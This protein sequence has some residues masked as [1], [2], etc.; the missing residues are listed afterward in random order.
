MRIGIMLGAQPDPEASI[1]KYVRIARDVES[2]GFSSLW[3]AHISEHDAVM[4][5]AL[6]GRETEKLEV[7]TAVVAVQPRHPV[8]LAQQA[9]TAA[10]YTGGR[11]TLG[12]GLAHKVVIEDSLGL[13]FSRP[14]R[15]MRE[16]L[17]VLTPLLN[18]ETARF[19]GDL[20]RVQSRVSV[21]DAPRPVPLLLAALGPM[22]LQIAGEMSDGT[23]LWMTG[24]KTIESHIRPNLARAAS[25]AGRPEPRIV[26]AF[27]IVLTEDADGARAEIARR[28]AVYGQLPSYRAMLDKEGATGPADVAIAGDER[29][30]RDAIRRVE[31]AGTTDFGAVIIET[32]PGASERT[33]E[34]LQSL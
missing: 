4:A 14:A 8:A 33:M 5:M 25:A 19:R 17:E 11:F 9:L 1:E 30:L 26:A 24:P 7:G 32:E 31:E 2:R 21:P 28:L 34:F 16:Y 15:T 12:V 18:G 3:M 6:A 23:A 10:A 13:S 27:P 20:Y 22:M 29:D